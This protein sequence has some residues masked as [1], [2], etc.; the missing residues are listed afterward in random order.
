M[1]WGWG[2]VQVEWKKQESRAPSSVM[3]AVFAVDVG[4]S[5]TH[6]EIPGRPR[7]CTPMGVEWAALR[8]NHVGT[9]ASRLRCPLR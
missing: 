1:G 4:V 6:H 2:G 8:D 5:A 3:A 9:P 7:G